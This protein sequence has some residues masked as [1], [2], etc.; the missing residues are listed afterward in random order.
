[1]SE[2]QITIEQARANLLACAAFLAETIESDDAYVEAVGEIVPRYLAIADV[3]C[4]AALADPIQDPFARDRLLTAIAEKCAAIDDDEYAFQLVESIEDY[5]LMAHARGRI[6]FQ[7]AAKNDFQAALKIADTLDHADNALVDIALH[8][9]AAGRETDAEASVAKIDFPLARVVALQNIA[10]FNLEK[11]NETKVVELLDDAAARTDEIEF[12]EEQIRALVNSANLYV[13]AKR[14]DRAIETL[15]RAKTLAETMDGALRD[16]LLTDVALGFLH[17]GNIDS[18]DGVLDLVNDKTQIAAC[19]VGFAQ[20]FYATGEAAEAAETLEEA[21]ATLK[22]QRDTETRDSRAKNSV[23]A[24]IAVAFANAEKAERALEIAQE[25][26]SEADRISALARLAQVFVYQ[27][28]IEIARQAINAIEDDAQRISAFIGA[29]EMSKQKGDAD[30]AKAYL[31]EAA[32]LIETVPQFTVRAETL[33]EIIR[34]FYEFGDAA[35]ARELALE[36]LR[37]I[38]Q[39]RSAGSRVAALARLSDFY[40]RDDSELNEKERE[41]LDAIIRKTEV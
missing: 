41:I 1:M 11:G 2:R 19:L 7:K 36:N 18:A 15:D 26:R 27:N 35:K 32:N 9:A 38:S 30:G 39:I 8:Q 23:F 4:A 31:N 25:N 40:E 34:R 21:Y 16:G 3:D 6:A 28:K 29:A 37:T 22:S 17:A 10:E 12:P 24:S 5:S 14:N 33:D 20:Q 13:D